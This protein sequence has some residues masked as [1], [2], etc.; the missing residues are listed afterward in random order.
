MSFNKVIKEIGESAVFVGRTLDLVLK[1]GELEFDKK[2]PV[3]G[4]HRLNALK[5]YITNLK[6][7]GLDT[8]TLK[9]SRDENTKI[10]NICSDPDLRAIAMYNPGEFYSSLGPLIY[11]KGLTAFEIQPTLSLRTLVNDI[12]KYRF[13]HDR[14]STTAIIYEFLANTK[15]THPIFTAVYPKASM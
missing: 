2:G 5:N 10:V 1:V 11:I 12:V 15:T 8:A 13:V 9:H 3:L 4:V 7:C 6:V 14:E